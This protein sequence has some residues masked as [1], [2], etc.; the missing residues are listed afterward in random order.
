M[1]DRAA[2]SKAQRFGVLAAVVALHGV[3]LLALIASRS[4]E[5]VTA[6]KP[7]VESLI[8]VSASAPAQRP[9]PPP[10]LPSEL[11][12]DV[13]RLSEQ[14]LALDPDSAVLAGLTGQCAT[15]D[16]VTQAIL[17]DPMAVA[18]VT[19]AP[20]ETRSIAEAIVMWNAGWSSAARG[21]EAPLSPARAV[22][23]QSLAY[24]D[25]NCLDEQIAGPRLIPVRIADGQRTM[26]LVFG[27]GN[28]TWRQLV[29]EPETEAV[30]DGNE[31]PWYDFDWL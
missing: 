29:S 26:F 17:A 1:I 22:V 25:D 18:A 23:E 9:P 7:G 6:T 27:S 4:A 8:S 12:D 19:H 5:T 21:L 14:A 10:N 15:L 16:A 2:P 3:L 11:Q 24:V 20:P 30:S 31:K 28:W 13:Q